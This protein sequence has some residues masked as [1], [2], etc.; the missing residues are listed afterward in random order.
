MKIL[1]LL[2]CKKFHSLLSNVNHPL[3]QNNTQTT[4][5][6][7][8]L[9]RH[10]TPKEEEKEFVSRRS[11]LSLSEKEKDIHEHQLQH[12]LFLVSNQRKI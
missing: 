11:F 5:T 9:F 3:H 1:P 7:T 8:E 4:H 6:L 2:L 10:K 12:I